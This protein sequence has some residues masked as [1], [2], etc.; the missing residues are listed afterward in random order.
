MNIIEQAWERTAAEKGVTVDELKRSLRQGKLMATVE[1]MA[2][3][4]GITVE[5]MERHNHLY[6]MLFSLGQ[7]CL[8]NDEAMALDTGAPVPDYRKEH[9][10]RCRH[11]QAFVDATKRKD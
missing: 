7:D 8:M 5:A 1:Q 11:C 6:A 9:V 10:G 3:E 2:A 4:R